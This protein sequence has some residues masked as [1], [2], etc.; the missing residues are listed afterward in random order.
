M[1]PKLPKNIKK[2]KKSPP[3]LPKIP[4]DGSVKIIE[5]TPRFFLIPLILIALL[6]I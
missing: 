3:K 1:A 4:R 2:T 5:I 6:Y